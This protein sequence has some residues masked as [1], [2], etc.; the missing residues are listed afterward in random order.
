MNTPYKLKIDRSK[1]PLCL[2]ALWGLSKILKGP[3]EFIGDLRR[4]NY[5][6]DKIKEILEYIDRMQ[7]G[8]DTVNYGKRI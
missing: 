1:K 7:D 5:S 8:D 3:G 4:R 2:G 6:D